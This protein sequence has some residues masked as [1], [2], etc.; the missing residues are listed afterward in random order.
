MH[1]SASLSASECLSK[2]LF[3]LISPQLGVQVSM[4]CYRLLGGG[5]TNPTLQPYTYPSRYAPG[6][7]AN[8]FSY[9]GPRHVKVAGLWDEQGLTA[10]SAPDGT[11]D[12]DLLKVIAS[13][14]P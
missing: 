12:P 6:G 7:K 11:L 4:L 13:D 5:T 9:K 2:C 10:G 8:M 3:L 1:R 14:C